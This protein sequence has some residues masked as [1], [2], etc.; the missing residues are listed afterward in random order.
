MVEGIERIL[1]LLRRFP[2]S[3]TDHSS[4]V[5]NVTVKTTSAAHCSYLNLVK[6][7]VS[8]VGV[9]TIFQDGSALDSSLVCMLIWILQSK[10]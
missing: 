3:A 9:G 6:P 2:H 5:V 4:S 10:N 1:L 8:E 7:I